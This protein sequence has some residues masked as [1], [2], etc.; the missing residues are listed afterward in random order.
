MATPFI[1]N[2]FSSDCYNDSVRKLGR[3]AVLHKIDLWL[4]F[5][6][7][8]IH[9]TIHFYLEWEGKMYIDASTVW[10]GARGFSLVYSAST[11]EGQSQSQDNFIVQGFET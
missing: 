8:S 1:S 6:Q 10:I 5:K 11:I 3:G 4:A 9:M 7:E 2:Y